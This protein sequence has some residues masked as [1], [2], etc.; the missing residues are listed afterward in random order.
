MKKI[1]ATLAAVV[2][3]SGSLAAKVVVTTFSNF[4]IDKNGSGFNLE[5][6]YLGY[7]YQFDEHWSAKAVYDAGKGS[8][9]KLQRLGYLKNAYFN[10]KISGLSVKAGLTST[11]AFNAQEKLWGYR[12]VAKSMMDDKGWQSSADLG[13]NLDYKFCDW[14]AAD[15]SVFN[16]E[17][18]KKLQSDKY[19][20]YAAGITAKPLDG[21][22]L[23]VYGD[24]QPKDDVST[25]YTLA[26]SAGYTC[27]RFR[28]GAE[29]DMDNNHNNVE[30]HS[31]RGLS[32][33]GSVRVIDRLDI[34]ARYDLGNS[35]TSADDAWSY[36]KD[37]QDIYAGLNFDACKMVSLSPNVHISKAKDGAS[38]TC[39][40]ISAKVN[41]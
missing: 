36:A 1:F 31:L 26:F 18:Y 3:L 33:Y 37:G 9:E 41:F 4:S 11:T 16:G 15:L 17:G 10:Y 6:V 34:F 25:D 13:L 30:G 7:D 20:R 12:Y 29:Y 21:L 19:F 8:D 2:L 5:R 24:L 14:L 23:R 40:A 39:V 28:L 32:C 22:Q 27:K 35:S 38:S